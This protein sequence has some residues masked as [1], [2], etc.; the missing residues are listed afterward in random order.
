MSWS[1]LAVL[2]LS[3]TGCPDSTADPAD[4][5]AEP[6]S[7][8]RA[9]STTSAV[10]SATGA[11]PA[12]TASASRGAL[13]AGL[14]RATKWDEQCADGRLAFTDTTLVPMPAEAECDGPSLVHYTVRDSKT[15]EERDGETP[16]FCCT[17]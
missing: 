11:G 3:I 10:A 4:A 15:G 1:C 5:S 2:A 16:V 13:R 8:A 6:A 12:V 14:K 17:P 7:S 9:A